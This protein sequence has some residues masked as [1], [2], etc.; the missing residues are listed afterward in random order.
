MIETPIAASTPART[1]EIAAGM[2]TLETIPSI[3]IAPEPEATR[4]AP[5]TPPI[6]A[7]DDEDGIPNHQVARF[8]QIAP[9]RP[10]RT[11]T[12]VIAP[13]ST[14]PSAMVAATVSEMKAPAKLRTAAIPTATF[15][16]SAPVAIVVAIALAVSWKPLVKSKLTPATTT[17]ATTMSPADMNVS[18]RA[19]AALM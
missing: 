13:D 6:S 4:V 9:I 8:Q 14:M 10:P 7:W 17:R 16:G 11:T 5:I 18:D 12:G 2:I 15:G 3:S 1:G 19:G